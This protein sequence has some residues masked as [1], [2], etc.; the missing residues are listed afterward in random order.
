MKTGI[1]EDF[2]LAGVEHF[3]FANMGIIARALIRSQLKDAF[4]FGGGSCRRSGLRPT[5]KS[6]QER[7]LGPQKRR[8]GSGRIPKGLRCFEEFSI[9]GE[10]KVYLRQRFH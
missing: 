9:L 10:M 2:E 6:N 7:V 1:L 5:R 8:R 3:H 4:S